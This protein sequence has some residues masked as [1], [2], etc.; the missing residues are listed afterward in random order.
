M[1][2]DNIPFWINYFR[3]DCKR[4][5]HLRSR[6]ESYIHSCLSVR[7]RDEYSV[8]RYIP[9]KGGW[10][11]ILISLESCLWE[12]NRGII[13]CHR[14]CL[15]NTAIQFYQLYPDFERIEGWKSLFWPKFRI[16]SKPFS[17]ISIIFTI[18]VFTQHVKFIWTF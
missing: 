9:G 10:G 11:H 5:T 7:Y 6:L 12:A 4:H 14:I 18:S 15:L 3:I 16:N 13:L 1:A 2:I 17:N 8:S